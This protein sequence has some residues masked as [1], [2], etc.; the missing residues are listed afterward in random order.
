MTI[1]DPIRWSPRSWLLLCLWLVGD[2]VPSLCL[3]GRPALQY[4]ELQVSI[5]PEPVRLPIVDA[6]DNRFLRLSTGEGVS[7]TKVDHMVQD[8]EG[9]MWFGTRYGL[10]RYDG[11]ALKIFVRDPGNPNSLDG[12]VV[13]ALFKDRE[14]AL[15]VACDQ[16]L[17][18]FDPTTES[19]VRYPIPLT[20]SITQATTGRLW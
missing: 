1:L 3:A 19:F 8:N 13:R 11:Y 17:N 18:K 4:A 12:I 20:T 16:S 5:A 2:G 10:Y 9:F 15:W 7:Q 14:G 6:T